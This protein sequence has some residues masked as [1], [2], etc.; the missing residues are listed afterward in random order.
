M[1]HDVVLIMSITTRSYA[2]RRQKMEETFSVVEE[3]ENMSVSISG[4]GGDT[5]RAFRLR[6][7]PMPHVQNLV[8]DMEARFSTPNRSKSMRELEYAMMNGLKG[9]RAGTKKQK[10]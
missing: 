7:K 10:R 6:K 2:L 5:L 9:T 3:G 1:T 4:G 8:D